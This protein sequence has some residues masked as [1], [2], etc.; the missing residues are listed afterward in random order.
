MLCA[1]AYGSRPESGS[2]GV[3]RMYLGEKNFRSGRFAF[4][5]LRL[6]GARLSRVKLEGFHVRYGT[7]GKESFRVVDCSGEM[8]VL[9]ESGVVE[10]VQSIMDGWNQ[11]WD[12]GDRTFERRQLPFREV[13]FQYGVISTRML[14]TAQVSSIKVWQRTWSTSD[15]KW[16]G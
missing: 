14:L 16:D 15:S 2:L 9:R 13:S 1:R 7:Y 12:Q 5:Y 3:G 8:L 11:G 10:I 4:R 6:K